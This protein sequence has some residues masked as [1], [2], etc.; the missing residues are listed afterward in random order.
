MS[1][2]VFVPKIKY[3]LNDITENEDYSLAV[4]PKTLLTIFWGRADKRD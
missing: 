4:G 2:L 1:L 3:F